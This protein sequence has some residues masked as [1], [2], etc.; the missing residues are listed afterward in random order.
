MSTARW[1]KM[2]EGLG[3]SGWIKECDVITLLA[4]Q[5]RGFV[6][7]VTRIHQG[8]HVPEYRKIDVETYTQGYLDCRNDILA[9][10]E[11]TP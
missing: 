8:K 10:M 11:A 7:M 9:A 3:D 6:R 2:V 5:H 1:K 4:R